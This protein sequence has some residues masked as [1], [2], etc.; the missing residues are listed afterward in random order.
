MSK[1]FRLSNSLIISVIVLTMISSHGSVIAA[2]TVAKLLQP[3]LM[4]ENGQNPVRVIALLRGWES[5]IGQT[6]GSDRKAE[7]Y[8]KSALAVVQKEVLAGLDPRQ[9][10][11]AV[12]YRNLPALALEVSPGGLESLLALK[13]VALVEKDRMIFPSGDNRLPVLDRAS[14]N[15][16]A[17]S[18]EMKGAGVSIAF[19]DTGVDYTAVGKAGF[20]NDKVIGGYDF[21]DNDS[22]PMD[23]AGHG[24]GMVRIA[25]GWVAPEAKVYAFKICPGCC[26]KDPDWVS[27][28]LAA[29]DWCLTNK[30]RNPDYPIVAINVSWDNNTYSPRVCDKAYPAVAA[31][32]AKLSAKG[33]AVFVASGNNGFCDGMTMPACLSQT[34]SV[35]AVYQRNIG[36]QKFC[37]SG[38]ACDKR[39]GKKCKN[40]CLD[41]PTVKDLVSCCSNSADFLDLLAQSQGRTSGASAYAAGVAAVIQGYYKQTRGRLLS[42]K[43]L[44]KAMIEMADPVKD[45]KSKR[46]KPRVNIYQVYHRLKKL[47]WGMITAR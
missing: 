46:V 34:I 19:I 22:D 40:E 28:M 33:I 14:F 35:G 36:P 15:L 3:D 32:A 17:I 8:S 41:D 11:V 43:E 27:K 45:N 21:G 44:K 29:W 30:N 10:R 31:A 37:V 47:D 7:G 2:G 26:H 39:K 38:R 25:A 42:V 4:I 13:G 18:P 23:C 1:L 9:V 5:L 16:A 20:P 6:Q 12:R 24:T